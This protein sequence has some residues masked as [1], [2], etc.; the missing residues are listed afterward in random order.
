MNNR[1]A[2]VTGASSGIGKACALALAGVGHR[3]VLAARTA[4]KLEEVA[5]EIRGGNGEAFVVE[6]DLASH[7]SIKSAI[8]KAAKEFGRIDIL[9]NNAGVTKDGLGGADEA[10]RLGIRH[11]NE[12]ERSVLCNTRSSTGNDA[13]ALGPDR[14]HFLGGGRE[15]QSR[16]GELCGLEGGFDWFNEVAGVGSGEPQHHRE[17][18]CAR[19]YWHRHDA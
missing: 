9:V 17:C 18:S 11:P 19:L 12:L 6:M 4:E 2:L 13:R 8:G 16:A 3:V 1:T 14:K 7:D 10:A 5:A 15:G